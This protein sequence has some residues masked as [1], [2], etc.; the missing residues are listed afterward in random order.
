MSKGTTL[1]QTL[2][3]YLSLAAVNKNPAAQKWIK[4]QIGEIQDVSRRYANAQ[5]TGQLDAVR[6]SLESEMN[7]K[8][9]E[10]SDFAA[11][12]NPGTP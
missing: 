5:A 3:A 7:E 6:N 11:K 10:V 8:Q 4:N 12:V 1:I 9:K 2:T